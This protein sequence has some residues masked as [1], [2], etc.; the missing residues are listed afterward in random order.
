MKMYAQLEKQTNQMMIKA[1]EKCYTFFKG[2]LDILE[3]RIKVLEGQVNKVNQTGHATRKSGRDSFRFSNRFEKSSSTSKQSMEISQPSI[4]SLQNQLKLQS[5]EIERLREENV[6][7]VSSSEKLT[8]D[9]QYSERRRI[10]FQDRMKKAVSKKVFGQLFK[11]FTQFKRE[12]VAIL[13][14]SAL[15]FQFMSILT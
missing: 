9:L 11:E 6:D 2:K 1:F 15:S 12:T 4:E 3:S 5:M 14:V 7:L 10:Y 13:K 8:E